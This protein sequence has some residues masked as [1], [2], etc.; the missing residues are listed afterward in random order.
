MRNFSKILLLAL[1]TVLLV[2]ASLVSAQDGGLDDDEQAILDQLVELSDVVDSYESYV[3][4]YL[5]YSSSVQ[6][7]D[8]GF[9]ALSTSEVLDVAITAN[10]I[11]APE[12]NISAT[13]EANVE[14]FE[15]DITTA[16][17]VSAEAIYIVDVLYLNILDVAAMEGS[18]APTFETGWAVA[19]EFHPFYA[20][21]ALSDFTNNL[22]GDGED[23]EAEEMMEILTQAA[24][25]V[26][27]EGSEIDGVAVDVITV[28][29]GFEG[30][31][32]LMSDQFD[33]EDPMQA[34]MMDMM[35]GTLSEQ[36]DLVTYSIAIDGDGN[37]LGIATEVIF[38]LEGLD[39]SALDESLEDATMSMLMEMI[40]VIQ[41][42]QINE[43]LEPVEAPE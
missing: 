41:F 33:T 28:T 2:S 25:S 5:H 42:S 6:D 10:V 27:L 39:I 4:D 37:V 16:Y 19:D 3:V 8:L 24:T 32:A 38:N 7:M 30:I 9:F 40:D 31:M 15:D 35:L 11:L 20:D 34:A 12:V 29:V 17:T 43:A 36:G 1:I 22:L 23:G 13:I 18:E 26:T 14:R 21:L